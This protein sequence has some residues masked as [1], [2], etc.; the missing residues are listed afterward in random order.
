MILQFCSLLNYKNRA[1]PLDDGSVL[2]IRNF[3]KK[4]L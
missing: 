1:N 2:V 4:K 3:P